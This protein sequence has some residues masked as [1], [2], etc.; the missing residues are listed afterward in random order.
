MESPEWV[1]SS[2]LLILQEFH[3][4]IVEDYVPGSAVLVYI[5]KCKEIH[6]G[7]PKGSLLKWKEQKKNE[8]VE[9][10]FKL[11]DADSDSS[12]DAKEVKSL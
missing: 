4:S 7:V 3:L 11:A 2:F 10:L 12:V 1:R 9:E 8:E 5:L 6:E